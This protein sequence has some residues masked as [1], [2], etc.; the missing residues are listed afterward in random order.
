MGSIIDSKNN[1]SCQH[2]KIA[3]IYI[4][5]IGPPLSLIFLFNGLIRIISMKKKITMVRFLVLLI[6]I[7]E[8]LNCISHLLQ[9]LKYFLKDTTNE[10]I[11]KSV[12]CLIQI[13]L[14]VFSDY[15]TLLST[16]LFS[17][18]CYDAIKYNNNYFSEKK[19]RKFFCIL[20]IL[21]SLLFSGG[22]CF[23]DFL[24]YRNNTDNVSYVE[25]DTCS[26]WCWLS[27][28]TSLI[29]YGVYWVVLI[30]NI[31]IAFKNYNYLNIKYNELITEY[32]TY[33]TNE[34]SSNVANLRYN[35]ISSQNNINRNDSIANSANNS[36]LIEN[37]N[38]NEKNDE[39]NLEEILKILPIEE[40]KRVKM[41]KHMRNKF[42]F[43]PIITILIFLFSAIYRM[44]SDI[45]IYDRDLTEWDYSFSL[46][47][48]M[49]VFSIFHTILGVFR[50]ILYGLSFILFEEKIFNNCFYSIFCPCFGFSKTN[51]E[52]NESVIIKKPSENLSNDE[53]VIFNTS[54]KFHISEGKISCDS[55]SI[56][57]SVEYKNSSSSSSG[58]NINKNKDKN[59][60][61]FDSSEY[62][63]E[64]DDEKENESLSKAEM[65]EYENIPK[66]DSS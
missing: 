27:H 32:K 6:F 46:L 43:Y 49:E 35:S 37:N 10:N 60:S 59:N 28:T 41:L 29:C 53:E 45:L 26:Y 11:E 47:I 57:N 44:F 36:H 16:L 30:L 18:K 58:D 9:I 20:V 31:I 48:F 50:G 62:I 52:D 24:L 15:C 2:I 22:F 55:Y 3:I 34:Q 64:H 63:L 12:I 4:N 1:V 14:G 54:E 17:F 66:S 56:K 39:E 19:L 8:I 21:I 42:L 23:L 25:R 40:R 65:T 5:L 7:S 33:V 38:N 13:F 61:Q 51:E